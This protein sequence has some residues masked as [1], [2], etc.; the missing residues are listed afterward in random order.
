MRQSADDTWTT[1]RLAEGSATSSIV[2]SADSLRAAVIDG[3]AAT[4]WKATDRWPR[5]SQRFP[6]EWRPRLWTVKV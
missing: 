6:G 5:G 1:S 3:G 4:V 2:W